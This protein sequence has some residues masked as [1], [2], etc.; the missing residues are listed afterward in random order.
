MTINN[1]SHFKSKFYHREII[2]YS[3]HNNDVKSLFKFTL[4]T[5]K[6]MSYAE[7]FTIYDRYLLIILFLLF[8]YNI[9]TNAA[10][11]YSIPWQFCCRASCAG[12]NYCILA[13]HLA[14]SLLLSLTLQMNLSGCI[15]LLLI[16]GLWKH[17]KESVR[18]L[19]ST[20]D[21]IKSIKASEVKNKERLET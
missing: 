16:F 13:K 5:Q 17:M 12:F 8:L 20:N 1:K 18:F 7:V 11:S 21:Q 4:K 15:L 3:V 19:S 14:F 2:A 9:Q 10:E 6:S